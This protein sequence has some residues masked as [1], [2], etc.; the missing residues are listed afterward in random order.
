MKQK[1]SGSAAEYC[2]GLC[3]TRATL[4]GNWSPGG[5]HAG[6]GAP[7]AGPFAP[8]PKR[9]EATGDP[10]FTTHDGMGFGFQASGAFQYQAVAPRNTPAA[11]EYYGQG[12]WVHTLA[13][14]QFIVPGSSGE[15]AYTGAVAVEIGGKFTVEVHVSRPGVTI[16]GVDQTVWAMSAVDDTRHIFLDARD[17]DDS[18][19][20]EVGHL[21]VD[22]DAVDYAEG[23]G[24]GEG[25]G[26]GAGSVYGMIIQ[27]G[28]V[29]YILNLVE[30]QETLVT[31]TTFGSYLD[32]E[33]AVADESVFMD[34][35][36]FAWRGL[37]GDPQSRT[38]SVRTSAQQMASENHIPA[39]QEPF[40][41]GHSVG[42]HVGQ[43]KIL[44]VHSACW[45]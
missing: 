9:A 30:T 45:T 10:H 25:A 34:S 13:A 4:A 39:D 23:E 37:F 11:A 38:P 21:V 16:N 6:C 2:T 36:K 15:W 28:N 44:R 42:L 19:E 20:E 29:F 43:G 40:L 27:D 31:V 12:V 33:L 18:W 5:A 35:D 3:I 17:I 7:L 8:P 32:V 1:M 14:R 41:S 22:D 24:E 26:S